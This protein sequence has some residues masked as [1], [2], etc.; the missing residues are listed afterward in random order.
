[1][2]LHT[3][4]PLTCDTSSGCEECLDP[5]LPATYHLRQS[6]GCEGAE[7]LLDRAVQLLGLGEV[8]GLDGIVK[9]LACGD[10]RLGL[11]LCSL[12]VCLG[13]LRRSDRIQVHAEVAH[14]VAELLLG[15]CPA[16]RCK[17]WRLKATMG[18]LF[19]ARLRSRERSQNLAYTRKEYFTSMTSRCTR[20]GVR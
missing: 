8:L 6:T 7:F 9:L 16:Q 19:P 4:A 5:L 13:A 15:L 10:Q 18:V 14:L 11:G 12:A 1:M 3:A 17:Q 2:F 20:R